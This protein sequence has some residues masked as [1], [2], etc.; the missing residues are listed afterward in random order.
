M[1]RTPHPFRFFVLI[2]PYAAAFG[3]SSVALQ[4][5]ATNRFGVSPDDFNKAIAAA[6][7]VHGLKW[8]WAPVVDT[9]LT[10]RIWYA[11]AVALA[12]AGV[13]AQTLMP[14][15][16][17]KM[18]LV[19]TVVMLSQIP[20]TFM[21]MACETF[22]GALPDE[23]KGRAAGFYQAGNFV[24]LGLGG[25]LALRLTTSLPSP[26]MAGAI[27]CALMVPCIFAS[28]GMEEPPRHGTG[29][30]DAIIGLARDL[31][32]MVAT[33]VDGRWVMSVG[34]ITGLFICLSPVG[35][36]AASSLFPSIAGDWHATQA[37]VE[38]VNGWLGGV[39]GGG[40]ALLGGWVSD[41]MNRKYAYALAGALTA[42]TGLAMGLLPRVPA[43]YDVGVLVYTACNGM[44]FG[45]FSAFVLETIGRGAVATK[46]NIFASLANI[47][48]AYT[49]RVDSTAYKNSGTTHLFYTDTALTLAGIVGLFVIV[50][51]MKWLGG[52]QP[53]AAPTS[54]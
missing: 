34:G 41:R 30:V 38:A 9:T 33:N 52:R 10:K 4:F 40:G 17:A 18:G 13:M 39:L 3:Y 29:I 26:W 42:F 20:L 5:V 51:V 15:S 12:A 1:T 27:L 54:A 45:T 35:A 25:G 47:A 50:A 2:L 44:A 53:A 16:T 24:G 36:G 28:R 11:V 46:Y 6:F 43:T 32:D 48:V 14:I 7:A 23:T 21:G 49:G 8:M 31:R 37:H 22:L 19:I